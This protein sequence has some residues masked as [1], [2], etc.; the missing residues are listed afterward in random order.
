MASIVSCMS[1]VR[2]GV[3]KSVPDRLKLGE[4]E[5]QQ[6][7][8]ELKDEGHDWWVI[9][10]YNFDYLPFLFCK[11]DHQLLHDIPALLFTV[12]QKLRMNLV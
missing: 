11:N 7:I 4:K 10:G 6:A 2:R 5:L 12:M 8:A 3:A 9:I 1:W